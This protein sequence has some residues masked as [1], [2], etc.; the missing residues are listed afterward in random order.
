MSVQYTVHGGYPKLTSVQGGSTE[1]SFVPTRFFHKTRVRSDHSAVS[2]IAVQL[3]LPTILP[4]SPHRSV[5]AHSSRYRRARRP[6]SWFLTH[7]RRRF[8]CSAWRSQEQWRRS[9][10]NG[11][12]P[13]RGCQM[14]NLFLILGALCFQSLCPLVFFS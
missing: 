3:R 8:V 12:A 7:L 10:D 1:E 2:E 4:T 5:N 13:L 6:L 11:P 9:S 14:S